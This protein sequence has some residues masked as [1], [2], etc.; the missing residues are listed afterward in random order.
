MKLPNSWTAAALSRLLLGVVAS[1][2]LALSANAADPTPSNQLTTATLVRA[3]NGV[4]KDSCFDCHLVMEGMSLVFTNDIHYEK[5][6][7][8]ASCHGGDQTE[9]D[10]NISMNASH[11]F[12]VRVTRQGIPEYCAKC[13]SDA[14]FISGYDPGLPVDQ[15]A[16]YTNSVHGKLLAAGRKRAAECVDCH[17]VHTIRPPDEPLSTASPQRIS[18]TCAKCHA[19]TAEAYL[20]TRHG[21]LFNTERRPGCTVCHDGHD[22]Q[23]ATTAMLTGST[24]VCARCHRPGTPAAKSADD[25]AKYL[26]GLEAAG[27]ASKDAL[28]RARVAVHSMNLAEVKRAAEPETAP[29][30][31]DAK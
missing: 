3:T 12:K 4:V 31:S 9:P 28:A 11:G 1:G 25:L 29:P 18:A 19:S 21:K 23:P 26:A 16:K 15:L 30:A 20:A 2:A 13:H 22:T 17:A 5:G 27:P 6:F 10:Q 24:S 7:S 14:D 8:C